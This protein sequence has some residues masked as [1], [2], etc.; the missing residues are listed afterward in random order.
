MQLWVPFQWAI[1]ISRSKRKESIDEEAEK[2][3]K[4]DWD[5][6][7]G[8]FLDGD[9]VMGVSPDGSD[10]SNGCATIRTCTLQE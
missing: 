1:G 10:L 7:M 4:V 6:A 8:V 2:G 9:L 3:D 5:L